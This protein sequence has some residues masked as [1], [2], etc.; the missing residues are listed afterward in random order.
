MCVCLC[1]WPR[2]Y[3]LPTFWA[4]VCFRA[5]PVQRE[6]GGKNSKRNWQ[7]LFCWSVGCLITVTVLKPR[8]P[9][10]AALCTLSFWLRR[11]GPQSPYNAW[12]EPQNKASTAD[13]PGQNSRKFTPNQFAKRG[14]Q[15]SQRG[16][17]NGWEIFRIVHGRP[18]AFR[19]ISGRISGLI[20]QNFRRNLGPSLVGLSG[21]RRRP[22]IPLHRLGPGVCKVLARDS[23]APRTNPS[24]VL[25][26]STLRL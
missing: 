24:R 10:P 15:F 11:W 2:P 25:A 12:L 9:I 22:E 6:F 18:K 17:K 13:K 8:P 26:Q 21:Q 4:C 23:A 19:Q 16:T 14:V 5:A 3:F 7:S 1:V 20:L